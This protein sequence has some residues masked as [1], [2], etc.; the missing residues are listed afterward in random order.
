MGY[1]LSLGVNSC[2][3]YHIIILL[4]KPHNLLVTNNSP[5]FAA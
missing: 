5:T 2:D 4:N 1:K 3:F